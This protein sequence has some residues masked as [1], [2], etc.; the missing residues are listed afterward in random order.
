MTARTARLVAATLSAGS[1]LASCVGASEP[2][3]PTVSGSSSLPS[4][5][6]CAPNGAHEVGSADALRAA[7]ATAVPGA[8]IRL[9]D[10][11]YEGNFVIAGS[12]TTQQPITLCGGR[13]AVLD[14][15]SPDGG[16]T[17]QLR[18]A[19]HWQVAGFTIRGG[20]KGLMADETQTSI[21]EGLSILDIGDEALHLR[22][23]SSDNTVRGNTIRNTGLRKTKFGEGIYIGSAQSN[24]CQHSGCG[25]DRSDRNIIEGNDIARTTAESVDIKEGTTGGVLR[26]N[27][28]SGVGMDAADSWVN[29]KGN[30]W[31]I[32]DNTGVDTPLDGFQTHVILDG[33]GEH[34]VFDRNTATLNG[35]GYAINITKRDRG[36]VVR[37]SN[38][39][40]G[41]GIRLS[42]IKCS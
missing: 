37:C 15:G 42:T 6:N 16:T 41:T 11:R 38:R 32:E 7:L 21:I 19:Q 39:A 30:G 13:G 27:T 23:G 2:S 36:N 22:T 1:L 34:N 9:A 5:V 26:R 8:T 14:G 25:P 10:G 4:K 12:G 24:W 29:V 3:P 18:G 17:L 20:K 40:I 31:T 35:P 33:W 28:F